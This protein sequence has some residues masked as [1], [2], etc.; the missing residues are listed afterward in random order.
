MSPEPVARSRKPRTALFPNDA[1]GR[2]GPALP[3]GGALSGRVRGA[4]RP[5]GARADAPTEIE[6]LA[7][8]LDDD[9]HAMSDVPED[10]SV[11]FADEGLGREV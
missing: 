10:D 5:G 9:F 2:D 1:P 4:G 11:Q 6:P 3:H 8:R 7:G